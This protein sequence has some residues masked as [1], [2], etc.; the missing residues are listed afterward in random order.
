MKKVNLFKALAFALTLGVAFTSC[1]NDDDP[2]VTNLSGEISSDKTIS[3]E[4]TIE[5]DVVVKS[6]STLTI[7]AGTKIIANSSSISYILVEQ[8]AKINAVGTAEAPI[9]F[10]A[11]KEEVGAW[12]G[13]HLCGKAPINVEGGK[14]TSEIG[15]SPY[16][17]SD[18]NDNSGTLKYCVFSYTGIAL[19]SEHE[20]NGISF[21][22]VGSG[23]TVDYVEIYEGGDDGVEF[24]G[25]TVGVKHVLV[26]YAKDDCFDWTEGWS[27]K[28]QYLLAIQKDGEGD[29][30]IEGDNS[31]NNNTA[32]PYSN[33]TL[34]QVTLLGG[35]GAEGYGMKLREGTKAT[36]NNVV[37]TGFAKRSI[38]VE[39]NQ[40]LLNVADGSLKVD[41]AAVDT[42]VTDHPIKYSV[43]KITDASG[44]EID[45]TTAAAVAAKTAAK[46]V[47]FEL[48]SN[49]KLQ[50]VTKAA[51]TT[52]TA[53]KDASTL[54]SFFTADSQIGAGDDWTQ[55]WTK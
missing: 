32:T 51:T 3:G 45:D 5:G 14:G 19:D 48:S 13:L 37:V 43:S 44:N 15:N 21:Y 26:K 7:E 39:H 30:G 6:G 34:S 52:F 46:A 29:R 54:G 17:G 49:L 41:Y 25:G 4:W 38:H 20:A 8:G 31:G 22:G 10:T 28:G 12:G 55:G 40:T 27:G 18:A 11:D 16:G 1:D 50:T 23:T 9:I 53:G 42:N 24:F 36:I 47:A 33:P 2:E 35:G